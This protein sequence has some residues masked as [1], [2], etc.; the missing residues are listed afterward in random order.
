MSRVVGDAGVVLADGMPIEA[1]LPEPAAVH[2]GGE[3]KHRPEEGGVGGR[4]R[5]ASAESAVDIVGHLVGEPEDVVVGQGDADEEDV[6]RHEHALE[7]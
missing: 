7:E 2:V 1:S 4:R 3:G 6:A 5:F